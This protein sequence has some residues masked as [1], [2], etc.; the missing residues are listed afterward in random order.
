M[1]MVQSRH[2]QKDSSGICAQHV[3]R[4]TTTLAIRAG[5]NGSADM[6]SPSPRRP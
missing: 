3:A 5:S 4:L 2:G 6:S 1:E